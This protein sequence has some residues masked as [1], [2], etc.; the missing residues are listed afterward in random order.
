MFNFHSAHL[1][2]VLS[3]GETIFLEQP[4]YHKITDCSLYVVK[5]CKSLYALKQAG[6]KWYD[7]LCDSLAT[8]GFQ[9]TMAD[10]AVFYVYVENNVVILFIH[11]ND[12]MITG[13][14]EHLIEEY[15]QRNPDRRGF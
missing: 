9:R 10:P 2:G 7:T 1:N 11:V 8:V 5:I 4:A 14:S 12:M 15:E 13:S 6:K 3:N